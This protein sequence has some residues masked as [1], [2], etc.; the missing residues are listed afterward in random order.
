M[1]RI[2]LEIPD[3]V[4]FSCSIQVRISDINYGNHVG[5]DSFISIIHEARVQ[6][7][8]RHEFTELSIDGKLGLIMA[9]LAAEFKAE[10]FYGDVIEVDISI[11]EITGVSFEIFYHLHAK[12]GHHSVVIA[13]AKTGMVCYDYEKKKVAA[14]PDALLKIIGN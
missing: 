14:V 12:R 9:E 4:I 8:S 13:K 2:K 5:N 6:W 1:A 7:L 3:T 11:G 10:A